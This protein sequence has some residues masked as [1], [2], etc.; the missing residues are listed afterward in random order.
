M[1]VPP[2]APLPCVMVIGASKRHFVCS[3]VSI[4]EER[5]PESGAPFPRPFQCG[6][7]LKSHLKKAGDTGAILNEF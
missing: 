1:R 3:L 2:N 6:S 4:G 5:T 7:L